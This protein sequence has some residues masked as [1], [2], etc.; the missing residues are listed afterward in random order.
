VAFLQNAAIT[1]AGDYLPHTMNTR[2][3]RRI[4]RAILARPDQFEMDW[5]FQRTLR[6]GGKAIPASGCGTA[7]CIAGWAIVLS[8]TKRLKHGD[9]QRADVRHTGSYCDTGK[10]LL[11]LDELQTELLFAV[12]AW[13]YRFLES[14]DSAPTPLARAKVAVARINYFIKHGE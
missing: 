8:Q 14:Y 10:R 9:V 1:Y 13:P 11:K 12:S 5:W 6:L 4:Q 7:A 2:L 3:L